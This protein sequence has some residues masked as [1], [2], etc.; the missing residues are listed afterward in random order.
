MQFL[1]VKGYIFRQCYHISEMD[2]LAPFFY[3]FCL[4]VSGMVVWYHNF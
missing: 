2:Y 4:S 1:T 3:T